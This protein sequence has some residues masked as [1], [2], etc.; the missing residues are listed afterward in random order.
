[1]GDLSVSSVTEESAIVPQCTERLD[2]AISRGDPPTP[3]GSELAIAVSRKHLR[4]AP[5]T[6][7]A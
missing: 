2:I 4:S 5:D 6:A 7:D 3:V 1:M